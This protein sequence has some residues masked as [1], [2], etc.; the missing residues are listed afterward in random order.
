METERAAL[1]GIVA[2]G[3]GAAEEIVIGTVTVI[4]VGT[5]RGTDPEITTVIVHLDLALALA[6]DHLHPATPRANRK[7]YHFTKSHP[8]VW[9]HSPPA[10]IRWIRWKNLKRRGC[11]V[12]S[13]VKCLLDLEE[14]ENRA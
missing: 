5:E 6:H 7:N 11:S 9:A 10:G 3:T 12:E 4:G 1:T 13:G 2:M 8:P 14:Q